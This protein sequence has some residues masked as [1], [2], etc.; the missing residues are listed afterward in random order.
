MLSQSSS[1]AFIAVK[2]KQIGQVNKAVETTFETN[3]QHNGCHFSSRKQ[4]LSYLQNILNSEQQH[5]AILVKGSR[6]AHMEYVVAEIKTAYPLTQHAK[7]KGQQ[8]C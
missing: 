1:D 8:S 4:L 3:K 6:S 2:Q 5:I 7:T